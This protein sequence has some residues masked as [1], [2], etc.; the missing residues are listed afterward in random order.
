[1]SGAP[2]TLTTFEG[3]S[4][5]SDFRARAL[6][7]RLQAVAPLVTAVAGRYVHLVASLEP[8][9]LQTRETLAALLIVSTTHVG[10]VQTA[11]ATMVGTE[12]VAQAIHHHL[13]PNQ[14]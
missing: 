12:A 3:G 10:F 11:Q 9:E 1:M 4:A 2:L 8:L 6:L 13:V 7:T 5:L 14:E